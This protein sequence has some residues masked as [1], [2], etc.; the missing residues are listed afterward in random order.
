MSAEK[1]AKRKKNNKK[2]ETNPILI[3]LVALIALVVMVA[4]FSDKKDKSR[5]E[6]SQSAVVNRN[7]DKLSLEPSVALRNLGKTLVIGES[8]KNIKADGTKIV[9]PNQIEGVEKVLESKDANALTR[10]MVKNQINSL[11]IDPMITTR[12]PMPENT[13]KNRLAL[14]HP[15]GRLSARLMTKKFFL[16]KITRG[17]PH[18]TTDEKRA[19]IGIVRTA[20]M[21]GGTM[22]P[23]SI[24][25]SLRKQGDFQMILTVRPVQNRHLSIHILSADTLENGAVR[26]AKK[27]NR[28]YRRKKFKKIFGPLKEALADK[29]TLEMGIVYDKGI[30]RGPRDNIF[31]W[32]I[33][34]PGIYGVGININGKNHRL[35]PW[36]PITTNMRTVSSMLERVSHRMGKKS[37]D[38][39]KNPSVPIERFRT[40]HWRELKPGG[41]V[42]DL[43]RAEP[44]IRRA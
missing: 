6:S 35:P 24:P 43:Y 3:A 17:A 25:A 42:V 16:Y 9:F 19:L 31:M 32:R 8:L 41:A 4:V 20:A 39:W 11:I 2:N 30:F 38:Y 37:R 23:D 29:I 22:E 34:E 44:S 26:L 1:N 13:V 5:R 12:N 33:I 7:S 10:L 40:V 15:A 14:A 27:L 18:L 21:S 36:Y 28:Y